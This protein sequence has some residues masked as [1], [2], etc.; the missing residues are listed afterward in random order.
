MKKNLLFAFI[1]VLFFLQSNAQAPVTVYTGA[2]TPTSQGWNELKL[3]ET[4]NSVAAPTTSTVLDGV[5]KLISTNATDQFSQ[6]AWYKNGFGIDLNKGFT[7]EIK[8]KVISAD[9]TGAFNIQG[10]DQNG[11]GFR[12][13][14]LTNSLTEQTNPFAAT[15]VI[16]DGMTNG[17]NLHIFT[18]VFSPTGIVTVFRDALS[19][20]SFRFSTFQYDN[21][22]ENGGFEDPEFPDFLSNGILTRVNKVLNPEKV[23][24]GNYSLEMNNNGLV[25][26]DWTNI[27]GARTRPIAVKPNKDYEIYITRRRT[28]S[29]PWCWRDMGAFYDYQNGVLNGADNRDPNITWGGFDR[30]WQTHPQNFTTTAE[31]KTVRFEFPTW[32]RDGTKNQNTT[33]FDN[34]TFREKPTT[35]V[36]VTYTTAHG[37]PAAEFP[38]GYVN[39][40]QNGDFEDHTINNDSSAY[41]WT[42]ASAGGDT[43]NTPVGFNPMWNGDVRIQD[44]N[45]PDDFN[46]GDEPYAHSGTNALRFST[47]NSDNLGKTRNFDFTVPLEANKTYRFN[48]WHRNP[49]WDD[50]GWVKVRI[51]DQVIW[52]MESRGRNNV[53]ANCDLVFTTTDT[54]KTLHLYTTS[55]DHGG[56]FNIYF[57][58]FVLYEVTDSLDPVIKGK[59]NLI[60]NGDFEDVTLGN[61]GQPYTW[62][63]AS[64]HDG[65]DDNYPVAWND[66]WGSVVRIQDKQKSTDTGLKWAHSGN[67]SLRFSYLDN[68]G[69]AQTFEGLSG[70]TLPVSYRVNLD[71]KKELEPDKTYTFV[72]W[73]K[74]SNYPDRGRLV[75]A[76]DDVRLWDQDLTTKYVDWTRH[77]ITFTTT[78][79]FHTLKLFTEFG[80]WFNFYLDDLFLFEDTYRPELAPTANGESYLAFGKS[81]GTSSTDVEVEYINVDNTGAF[82]PVPTRT[83]NM[84][85]D[86]TV[87]VYSKNSKLVVETETPA[88]V[89]IFNTVGM[90][91][92]KVKVENSKTFDLPVGSYIIKSISENGKVLS[93]KALNQ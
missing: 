83:E 8:A 46:S 1:A 72:F 88:L 45:K 21:I 80:G 57:D 69:D 66:M 78:S 12:V 54:N 22:I 61:D 58:D 35:P 67:N 52:G 6:L 51:G 73:L 53:W 25:T 15:N 91:V 33:S 76:N 92:A 13:G 20:G 37:I 65:N 16:A 7:I 82:N 10:F 68:W 62:A 74:S 77:Q 27:E 48:F 39:L 60:A 36:G 14:I 42:L 19:V 40:I 56:W 32:F 26:N 84:S 63:L 24:V 2:S 79:A 50:A 49:K 71:F 85:S 11:K 9:K 59:T 55:D 89:S 38:A 3:D 28:L 17:D 30:V 64:S 87:K 70:D 41:S 18:F 23:R 5:L 90:L 81:T 86:V 31:A 93:V 47:V 4:V 44:K 29:E 43:D 75:I 34:F